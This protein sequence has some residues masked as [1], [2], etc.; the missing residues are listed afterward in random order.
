MLVRVARATLIR[1]YGAAGAFTARPGRPERLFA[2]T[3]WGSECFDAG[4]GPEPRPA[5]TTAAGDSLRDLPGDECLDMDA[6]QC[7][8]VNGV[9]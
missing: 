6:A 4:A 8:R 2:P 7:G 5:S 1:S 3:F 9:D